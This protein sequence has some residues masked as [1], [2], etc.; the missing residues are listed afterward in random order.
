MTTGSNHGGAARWEKNMSQSLPAE[1]DLA[2][3]AIEVLGLAECHRLLSATSVGCMGLP[4][5]G[6]PELRPVNFVLDEGAIVFRTGAGKILEAGRCGLPA[7]LQAFAIEPL[8]HT[9]WSV[10]V[11]G[12]LSELPTN[13][14]TLRLPLRPWASGKKDSFVRLSMRHIS[15]V[16]IQPGRGNR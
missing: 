2:P 8:E 3:D 11:S 7:S 9:G 15:G 16:R 13:E 4:T 12:K 10:M 6:A 14:R 5:S 1:T